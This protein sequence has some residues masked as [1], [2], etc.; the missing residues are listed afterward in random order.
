VGATSF[1]FFSFFGFFGFGGAS[2]CFL[3]ESYFFVGLV[4]GATEPPAVPE[5]LVISS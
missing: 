3:D 4:R 2:L 5:T 1:S